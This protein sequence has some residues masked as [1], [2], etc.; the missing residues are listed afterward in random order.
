MDQLSRFPNSE[1][2]QFEMIWFL[3]LTCWSDADRP[4]KA[5]TTSWTP[6]TSRTPMT[7]RIPMFPAATVVRRRDTHREIKELRQAQRQLFVALEEAQV[8]LQELEQLQM[9]LL[10]A[11][12]RGSHPNSTTPTTPGATVGHSTQ[13]SPTSSLTATPTATAPSSLFPPASLLTADLAAQKTGVGSGASGGTS[14]PRHRGRG[15]RSR[16]SEGG[17]AAG[18]TSPG[19]MKSPRR[20]RSRP[21]SKNERLEAA[22]AASL[23]ASPSALPPPARASPIPE[24][25]EPSIPLPPGGG[26]YARGAEPAPEASPQDTPAESPKDC[27]TSSQREDS[28][29]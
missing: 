13:H 22:S 27:P 2:L 11:Y 5:Q 7:S 14:K 20:R 6:T 24:A 28:A 21:P 9:Q 19:N 3:M 18:T 8:E 4:T 17:E 10:P 29:P 23:G 12:A 15:I 16:R 26:V 25:R 1:S